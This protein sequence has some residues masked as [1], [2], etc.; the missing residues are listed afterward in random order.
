MKCIYFCQPATA[1][2]IVKGRVRQMGWDMTQVAQESV[3]QSAPDWSL[4][5]CVCVCVC[6]CVWT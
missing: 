1:K 3:Q 4:S 2:G 5:V 6:V